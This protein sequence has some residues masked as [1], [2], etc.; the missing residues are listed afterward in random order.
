MRMPSERPHPLYG[1][2]PEEA[3]A[4]TACRSFAIKAAL[5]VS[6]LTV[7]LLLVADKIRPSEVVHGIRQLAMT[8]ALFIEPQDEHG[9][10]EVLPDDISSLM[11]FSVSPCDN[12]YEFSCGTWLTDTTIPPD[13]A[14]I[15]KSFDTVATNVRRE[16]ESLYSGNFSHPSPD[17]ALLQDWYHACMDLATIEA[18]GAEP[19]KPVLK[20]IDQIDSKDS[21]AAAL[22]FLTLRKIH[23]LIGLS[24]ER[25]THN[26]SMYVLNLRTPEP[27][28]PLHGFVGWPIPTEEWWV[29]EG[30]EQEDWDEMRNRTDLSL[31]LD[32][33]EYFARLHVL[34]G[35]SEE[36]ARRAAIQAVWTWTE[37]ASWMKAQA[38]QD[39]KDY[40]SEWPAPTNLSTLESHYPGFPWRDIILRARESCEM[41]HLSCGVTVL[42]ERSNL[43]MIAS[44]YHARLAAQLTSWPPHRWV[45][46]L[47][48]STIHGMAPFLGSEYYS[49]SL[50]LITRLQGA[51]ALPSRADYCVGATTGA[52]TALAEPIY[53]DLFLP[54]ATELAAAKML[55]YIRKA[56][57]QQM[58][59][60]SWMVRLHLALPPRRIA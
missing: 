25:D 51:P 15:S 52:L 59:N 27:F 44:T 14:L 21:L 49:A 8:K 2:E 41:S 47:R 11:N 7:S 28:L 31:R 36:E 39:Q 9:S 34:V 56:F 54:P 58:Q 37:V 16:L 43:V 57:L 46:F 13:R 53:V 48:V 17:L 6:M 60:V 42:D 29:T 5:C 22:V 35:Y 1:A 24:V 23:P 19:I 18:V 45:A 26:Q 40:S 3:E 4:R 33:A 55:R 12:F 32:L 20:L 10:P 30:S 50:E 38:A